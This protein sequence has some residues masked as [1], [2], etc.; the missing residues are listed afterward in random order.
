MA[1]RSAT[2]AKAKPA[3][4]EASTPA[5]STKVAATPAP[6]KPKVVASKTLAAP[7]KPAPVS[8]A[9]AAVADKVQPDLRRK[10]LLEEVSRRTELP[11]H[12]VRPVMEAMIEV[13]GE[14]IEHGRT[15]NL[16]PLGRIVR[17]RHKETPKANV[18]MVRIRQLK[19]E[20]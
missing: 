9:P 11:K 8:V 18:S 3:K 2:K 19:T 7:E 15:M 14:A 10:D 12:K 17:K 5:Q 20:S 16:Q 1:T 6:Q 4:A 13:M